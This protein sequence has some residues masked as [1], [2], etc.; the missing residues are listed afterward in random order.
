[1]DSLRYLSS[2]DLRLICLTA[3]LIATLMGASVV[4]AV[5]EFAAGMGPMAKVEAAAEGFRLQV[6][7]QKE[8][9]KDIRAAPEERK[10]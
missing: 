1:M 3:M 5:R 4:L 9:R 2:K 7:L 10:R 8:L 6:K